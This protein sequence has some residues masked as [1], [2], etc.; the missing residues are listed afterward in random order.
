[1]PDTRAYRTLLSRRNAL[2]VRPEPEAMAEAIVYA[3]THPQ[4]AEELGQRALETLIEENRTPQAFQDALRR[5]YGYVTGQIEGE[6]A[7][8]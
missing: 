8:K 5:C 3:C 4:Q 6:T 7:E 2:V 1:V